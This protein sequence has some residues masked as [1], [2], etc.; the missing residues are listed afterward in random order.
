MQPGTAFIAVPELQPL[1]PVVV[2]HRQE[3]AGDKNLPNKII[4]GSPYLARAFLRWKI[5]DV[6]ARGTPSYRWERKKD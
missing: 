2:H 1:P 3:T 6:G 5:S 4:S